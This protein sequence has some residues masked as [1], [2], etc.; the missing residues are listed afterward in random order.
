MSFYSTAPGS[1][2]NVS[3]TVV[4][5]T[6][7]DAKHNQSDLY[8]AVW[9]GLPAAA[10]TAW[11]DECYV[12]LQLYPD[13]SWFAPGPGHPS[14][15]VAGNWVGQV[16]AWEISTATGREDTCFQARLMS[17][18]GGAPLNL[19][20]GDTLRITFSGYPN[21][22]TGEVVRVNDSTTGASGAVTLYNA[23][24]RFPVDPAYTT[25]AGA[26]A[27]LWSSGGGGGASVAFELGRG[28]NPS[29]IA[30]NSYGGCSPGVSPSTAFDPAVPCP[31]YDP[32]AWTNDTGRPWQIQPP[33]LGSGPS[34]AA[35][36]QVEFTQNAGGASA[37]VTFSNGTCAPRLGSYGCSYPW[38]SYSCLK[39]AF[40]F[41]AS[42]FAGVAADF[43]Q[44]LEYAQTPNINA[45][46]LTYYAPTNFSLPTCG[47]PA[48]SI[49]L[50]VAGGSGGTI[51]FLGQ[52]VGRS[53]TV[54]ALPLGSYSIRAVAGS[55]VSFEGWTVSGGAS[56]AA[57]SSPWTTVVV[58]GNGSVKASFGPFPRNAYV[59][60]NA[61]PN[62]GAVSVV[63]VAPNVSAPLTVAAGGAVILTADR[64]TI[65][66]APP[67]GYVFGH[68]TVTGSGASVDARG[69][70]V[71]GLAVTGS[72]PTV[73]VVAHY[74]RVATQ[75][76]VEV[77]GIGNG[78]IT[79]NGSTVPYY[80]SNRTSFEVVQLD[81]GTYP[82]VAVPATGWTFFGWNFTPSGVMTNFSLTTNLTVENGTTTLT[83]TFGAKVT[84][85]VGPMG[86]G[87]I[88]LNGRPPLAN[89][90]VEILPPGDYYLN[91]VSL[92]GY[93]F[94]H[95]NSS[96]PAAAWAHRPGVAVSL[97]EL[98]A[99]VTITATY[100]RRT[101]Q[102]ITFHVEP[103]GAGT[104]QFDLINSYRDNATN[105]TVT[106]GSFII[107]TTSGFAYRFVAWNTTG[108]VSVSG[109]LAAIAGNGSA[110]TAIFV[111]RQ[112]AITFV[113]TSSTGPS[114]ATINGTVVQSG[115]SAHLPVGTYPISATLPANTTFLGWSSSLP[116][117]NR[118]TGTSHATVTVTGAGT[119]YALTVDYALA[120]VT[121]TPPVADVGVPVT[122]ETQAGGTGPF[123]FA[124]RNL[125]PGCAGTAGPNVT[126]RP[127][128]AGTYPV[129]ASVT[130]PADISIVTPPLP[131]AV[132]TG[133]GVSS[134]TATPSV[135]DQG[136]STT[137]TVSAT[138]GM[139]PYRYSFPQ[140]PAGCVS[141]NATVLPCTPSGI[142]T[143]RVE[144]E[145]TDAQGESG[146]QNL[147]ITV[148]AD[149]SIVSFTAQPAE[150]TVGIPTTIAVRTAGGTGPLVPQ[151]RGLP[152]SG[153]L[154]V[155]ATAVT[156]TPASAGDTTISVTVTD[157]DAR[158]ASQSIV[159]RVNA[160]PA[161][162]SFSAAPNLIYLGSPSNF[163]ASA[164]GGTGGLVYAYSG[165]PA[166]CVEGNVSSFSCVPADTGSFN[167]TLRVVDAFGVAATATANLT[168]QALPTTGSG[169]QA[170]SVT[171]SPW[172]LDAL[173]GAIIV[174]AG[175]LVY[176]VRPRPRPAPPPRPAPA[177]P[178][179][180]PPKPWNEE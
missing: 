65:Q 76:T 35:P 155:N 159:L 3:W 129:Q 133:P 147:S 85:L 120:N 116:V 160:A 86:S 126:C 26:D 145:V 84:F 57:A 136:N 122:F 143:F 149:P 67:P 173:I 48:A 110:I 118:S 41:G 117:G 127:T 12:E 154:T 14:A 92:G 25:N 93:A 83:A 2:G 91:A 58:A 165:L 73:G 180:D 135:F 163:T 138:N 179:R 55:G 169:T 176:L 33:V 132:L 158:S 42:D 53:A 95:W 49:G 107:G 115:K 71:T 11:M 72:S 146:F 144:A 22:P 137:F 60:F 104:I 34:A 70:P 170:T 79:F 94:K 150:V 105:S 112:F 9:F 80:P 59:W 130:G 166:G 28:G 90:T 114:S 167:V 69:L 21:D 175:I 51:D 63:P 164:G 168:V 172:F 6:D 46:G 156:C 119:L 81:P 16:V 89:G 13:S 123:V 20:Q 52:V 88:S 113:S 77:I 10:P 177:A 125:P 38:F 19:T 31:S 139:S 23:T 7:A 29:V 131:Y 45:L 18:G 8:S 1:G 103:V 4:L 157:A 44:Y 17:A 111:L 56:L 108:P 128:A 39:S 142:G 68:W 15:T 148:N 75:A 171:Q 178:P 66:A 134:F 30:N 37:V 62:L 78:T 161:I 50:S 47:G 61:T 106:N 43:G 82:A 97:L 174:A 74:L 100:T 54:S 162:T 5:P 36:T 40:E 121:A 87:L 27:L 24:G 141:S 64:Y 99:S 32:V 152:S 96:D 98:N 102:N 151:F 140:L 153:C 101:T 124:W 109:G